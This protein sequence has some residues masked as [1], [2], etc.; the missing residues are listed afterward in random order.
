MKYRSYKNFNADSFLA[1][2]RSLDFGS[3][4]DDA[5]QLYDNL[6]QR[7]RK[8]IDKHAPLKTRIIRGNSAPFMNR[9]LN[10]AIYVRS[11]LKKKFNK[12][13][14]KENELKFKK[15]RNRCVSLRKKAIKAHFKKAT[16]NG[17]MSNKEFWNL[18]KPFLS[19]K[20]GL[21]EN[22]IMLVTDDKIVTDD[23]RNI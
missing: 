18:V 13:P 5:N 20:G 4:F 10:K 23:F 21:A 9:E 11:N 12:N 14:S 19:N 7:F 2:V 15:Q 22:D 17:H 8:V 16:E 3:R 6:T 1:D